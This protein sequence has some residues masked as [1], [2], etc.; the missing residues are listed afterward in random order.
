MTRDN[1][2]F[3]SLEI[4]RFI[5][6]LL[7]FISFVQ[8]DDLNNSA[9]PKTPIN[10]GGPTAVVAQLYEDAK[11]KEYSFTFPTINNFFSPWFDWKKEMKEKFALTLGMDYNTLHQS[12]SDS[13]SDI[14][15]ATSGA[16]RFYGKW[17]LTGRDT[18]DTGTLVFKFENRHKI[19]SEVPAASLGFEIGYNG[20]TGLL[21]NDAGA[22][23]GDLNWQQYFNE[24]TAGFIIGRYDPADYMDVLGYTNPWT[25]FSNLSILVN[26]SIAYTDYG[27]GTG[28][29]YSFDDQWILK[30]SI[31]D[32][33]ANM[34]ELKVF[35]NG[36]E[37][38]TFAQIEWV[39]GI[40]NRYSHNV[41][42]T[43]WHI[44]EREAMGSEESQGVTLGAN[45]TFNEETMLFGRFGL[46]D[47]GAPLASKSF[48]MGF[49]HEMQRSD[50]FGIGFSWE[51]PSNDILRNQYATE[52]FYRWQMGQ[53]IAI[54]PSIQWLKNP[55]LAPEQDSIWIGGLRF[56]IE[57]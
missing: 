44:D 29:A 36:S 48:V 28:I 55:A 30:A 23:V 25:T 31:S 50:M 17:T 43:L 8:A 33:N 24:G 21:F 40:D 1:K 26:S 52:V 57:M 14:D 6:L 47:G 22:I 5:I 41:H 49:T 56:R 27:M 51:E 16:L 19:N 38:F 20:I 54:T 45:W 46:S 12:A 35:N 9:E 37:F 42:M 10:F 34:T 18:K 2:V 11:P 53:H 15:D 7:V 3:K 39:P 4:K 32:A 13:I